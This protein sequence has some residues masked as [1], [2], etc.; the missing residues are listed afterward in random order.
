VVR[1]KLRLHRCEIRKLVF[2]ATRDAQV[3]ILA[4]IAE[5]S[6]VG[7][8]PNQSMVEQECRVRQR[9]SAQD[10]ARFVE[11]LKCSL[12]LLANSLRN[13]DQQLISK[14]ATYHSADLCNFLRGVT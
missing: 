7:G 10:K 14:F 11:T 8:V 4:S 3:Q 13:S 6:V 12:Q 1:K 2:E 5:Q 9:A